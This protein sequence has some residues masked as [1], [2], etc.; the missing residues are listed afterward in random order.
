MVICHL[1]MQ[2]NSVK[3]KKSFYTLHI[4]I[5]IKHLIAPFFPDFASVLICLVLF[6]LYFSAKVFLGTIVVRHS[7][8]DTKHRKKNK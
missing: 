6:C 2:R 7:L 5:I 8:T 3:A 1:I 4:C